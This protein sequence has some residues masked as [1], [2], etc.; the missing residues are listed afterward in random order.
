MPL[1]FENKTYC[2]HVY[3]PCLFYQT[4]EGKSPRTVIEPLL[5]YKSLVGVLGLGLGG[6]RF[7]LPPTVPPHPATLHPWITSNVHRVSGGF[8]R[9]LC[10]YW[11]GVPPLDSPW[12]LLLRLPPS[13]E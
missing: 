9:V 2:L 13:G 1:R 12:A 8:G 7:M 11:V 10:S 4:H 5:D 3:V 6:F